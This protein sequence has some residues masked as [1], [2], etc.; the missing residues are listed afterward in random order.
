MMTEKRGFA[1]WLPFVAFAMIVLS[2]LAFA[3]IAD[4]IG[5]NDDLH[6]FDL[7]VAHAL[8]PHVSPAALA[9]AGAITWLGAGVVLA[10]LGVIVGGVLLARRKVVTLYAWV[11]ALA[12][13]GLLNVTLKG[14]FMRDRPGETALLPSWSFPSAHAM[15]SLVTY[16]MLAYLLL[17]VVPRRFQPALV[18]TAIAIPLL[19]GASRVVLGFHYFSDVV[20]GFLAGFAWLAV[21]I[22]V[23][24]LRQPF[25]GNSPVARNSSNFKF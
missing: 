14:W 25:E 3:E 6:V 17:R 18:A 11:L 9:F 16:G 24:E 15:N 20:A 23:A 1:V 19:V 8:L 5:P 10:P 2:L 22:T 12:G 21:C 13:S 4:G 7:K